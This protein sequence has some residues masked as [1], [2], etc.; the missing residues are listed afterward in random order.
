MFQLAFQFLLKPLNIYA[1]INTSYEQ[2]M[3]IL[4]H[5]HFSWSQTKAR[6][7]RAPGPRTSW[8]T[9]TCWCCPWGSLSSRWSFL[10]CTVD[11]C[12]IMHQLI[13]GLYHSSLG[14]STVQGRMSQSFTVSWGCHSGKHTSNRMVI[15]WDLERFLEI[16]LLLDWLLGNWKS[17]TLIY[18][19]AILYSHV[20][21][22]LAMCHA[23]ISW[24]FMAKSSCSIA[25]MGRYLG[26]GF[27][28]NLKPRDPKGIFAA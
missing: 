17:M 7:H 9:A 14:V 4:W 21:L 12:E 16:N 5:H 13:G 1:N 8:R 23:E 26:H 20:K 28:D 27:H 22:P 11:G 3:K 2:P 24:S 10:S 6:F 19:L 25:K 18:N 15:S